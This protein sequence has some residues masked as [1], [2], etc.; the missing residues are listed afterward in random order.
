[1]KVSR[2]VH[3]C[4]AVLNGVQTMLSNWQFAQTWRTVHPPK[5]GRWGRRPLVHVGFLNSWTRNNLHTT[6][7]ER[8]M[9]I[10]RSAH[11]SSAGEP[12]RVILTGIPLF[13]CYKTELVSACA[14]ARHGYAISVVP[15]QQWGVQQSGP[16]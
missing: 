9:Q 15:H 11:P 12:P 3:M 16:P 10:L 13:S 7:T 8:L 6:V 14:W 5:R 4:C 1:M 2:V